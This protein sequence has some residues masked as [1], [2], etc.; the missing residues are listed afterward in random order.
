VIL[1]AVQTVYRRPLAI[2]NTIAKRY[3]L[4]TTTVHVS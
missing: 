3:R 2:V 4:I 1:L